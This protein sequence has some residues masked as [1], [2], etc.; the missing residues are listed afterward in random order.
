MGPISKRHVVLVLWIAASWVVAGLLFKPDAGKAVS[1]V[2]AVVFGI[3]AFAG[4]LW[5]GPRRGTR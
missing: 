4:L 1:F 5:L 2:Q 3:L